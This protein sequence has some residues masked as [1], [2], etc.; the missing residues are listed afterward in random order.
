MNTVWH[1]AAP[2]LNLDAFRLQSTAVGH[3][4]SA[5]GLDWDGVA[6]S[7]VGTQP[8]AWCQRR[9]SRAKPRPQ[10]QTAALEADLDRLLNDLDREI[11]RISRRLDETLKSEAGGRRA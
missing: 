1:D 9:E 5:K 7:L 4:K 6:R 8:S 11:A 3:N 2:I 10:C